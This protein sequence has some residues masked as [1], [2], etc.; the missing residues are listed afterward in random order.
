MKI[1]MSE[2]IE[3]RDSL[4]SSISKTKSQLSS[5]K[6]KLKKASNSDALKGDVKDAI[7]NKI[8]NYQVAFVDELCEQFGCYCTRL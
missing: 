2:V 8:N 5:A 1:K 6:K 7:D 3:Q 4:K